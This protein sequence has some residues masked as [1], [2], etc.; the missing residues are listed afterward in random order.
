MDAKD[1]V[2]FIYFPYICALSIIQSNKNDYE[3][4][5]LKSYNKNNI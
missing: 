5:G 3:P 2:L 1:L 4:K